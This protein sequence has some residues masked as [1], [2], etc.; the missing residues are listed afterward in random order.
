[1]KTKPLTEQA[2][3]KIN[4]AIGMFEADASGNPLIIKRSGNGAVIPFLKRYIGKRVIVFVIR[5]KEV[6]YD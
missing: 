4:N 5:D 6:K 2:T 3:I 1:M